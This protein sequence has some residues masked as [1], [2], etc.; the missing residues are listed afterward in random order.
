MHYYLH[1]CI[2]P[3]PKLIRNSNAHVTHISR[4]YPWAIQCCSTVLIQKVRWIHD[5]CQAGVCKCTCAQCLS[6]QVEKYVLY[7]FWREFQKFHEHTKLK[8]Q[9]WQCEGKHES[10]EALLNSRLLSVTVALLLR[11]LEKTDKKR[12]NKIKPHILCLIITLT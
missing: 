10:A 8:W 11:W 12:G 9:H 6:V 1:C 5:I 4:C 7:D 3:E 2:D